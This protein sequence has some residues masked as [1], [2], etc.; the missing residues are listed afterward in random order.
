MHSHFAYLDSLVRRSG[1]FVLDQLSACD[2]MLSFPAEIAVRQGF[3]E[4]MPRLADYVEAIHD[5]PAYVRALEKG[6]TYAYA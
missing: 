1:H 6:G 4:E 2:I 3:S 5:R